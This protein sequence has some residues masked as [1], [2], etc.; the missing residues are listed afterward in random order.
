MLVA[1]RAFHASLLDMK[2]FNE[3]EAQ[4]LLDYVDNINETFVKQ[5]CQSLLSQARILMKKDLHV[6]ARIEDSSSK[7]NNEDMEEILRTKTN[8][9]NFKL[10]MSVEEELLPLPQGHSD[11]FGF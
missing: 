4:V 8:I 9:T 10:D 6:A 7:F 3:N 2:L 1:V 11:G 5:R